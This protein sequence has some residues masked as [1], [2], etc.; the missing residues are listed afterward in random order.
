MREEAGKEGVATV[1]S[2]PIGTRP[3]C[4]WTGRGL[5][6]V[7]VVGFLQGPSTG[8]KLKK[9]RH[10]T[11]LYLTHRNTKKRKISHSVFASSHSWQE[12]QDLRGNVTKID[13]EEIFITRYR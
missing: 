9:A 4:G 11:K 5:Q 13:A 10:P 1:D 6:P 2:I 8:Q 7:T 3:S 12:S